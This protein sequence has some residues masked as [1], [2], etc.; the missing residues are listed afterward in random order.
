MIARIRE[1]IRG[2]NS[3]FPGCKIQEKQFHLIRLFE[4]TPNVNLKSDNEVKSVNSPTTAT[5][6]IE[7]KAVD[8]I[9]VINEDYKGEDEVSFNEGRLQQ[10]NF[11]EFRMQIWGAAAGIVL[12]FGCGIVSSWAVTNF[13]KDVQVNGA[14]WVD[15]QV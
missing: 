3:I 10:W 5:S 12:L 9:S 4:M 14:E 6:E 1:N 7:E 8:L 15:L 13:V 11:S 2:E